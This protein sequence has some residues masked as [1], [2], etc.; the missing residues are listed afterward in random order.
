MNNTELRGRALALLEKKEGRDEPLEIDYVIDDECRRVLNLPP[1]PAEA[2]PYV[3]W[4]T[5]QKMEEAKPTRTSSTGINLIK[6]WEGLRTKAYLCPA[7]VWTIGYGH[8]K[9]ARRGQRIN[10][11]EAERLLKEDLKVYE[12]AVRD[13]VSV[14]LN[15]NQFDALVSFCFNVGVGAFQN[16]TLRKLL[17][18]RKYKGAARQLHRWVHGGGRKLPGLVK[19]RND[20]YEL[21]TRE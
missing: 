4:M 11:Q 21:F 17:N 18:Q 13:Y 16:S 12:K 9:T 6:R 5:L 14:P 3:G 7:S 19:R 1:R 10:H 8:T 2:R 15:Q 20:E